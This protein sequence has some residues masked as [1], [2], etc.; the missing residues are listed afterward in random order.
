MSATRPHVIAVVVSHNGRPFL[1]DTFRALAA[2]TRPIDDIL[3]VD[4]GST[5]GSAN[6]ARSRLG[7][8]AVLAVRGK[9]GRAV[10]AA[11]RDPRTQGMDWLWLL[12]DDAAP[13]PSA[14][15]RL[16]AE[17][18]TRPKAW[19]L[20]PKLVDWSNPARLRS[21]GWSVDRTGRGV[22]RLEGEE[23][24]Q[25]QHDQ[26]T[27]VFFVS[28]AGMLVRRS[29]LVAVGGFDE[30]M[31]AWRDDLDL[32]WRM[33]L[34]GG[35]VLAVPTARVR[36]FGAAMSRAERRSILRYPRYL[37]ERHTVAS[38]IKCTSLRRLPLVL[39]LAFVGMLLRLVA[40]TLTGRPGD[41][42]QVLAAWGW[43]VKEL[44]VTLSLRRRAQ[45]RR[46]LDDAA[47]DPLRAPG[48]QRLRAVWRALLDLLDSGSGEHV[49][50]IS[51][52]E[53]DLP[54]PSGAARRFLARHPAGMM[55]AGLAVLMAVSLRSLL[56]APGIAG[57]AMALF[58][59]SARTLAAEFV[60]VFH[61]G[62]LGSTQ[63]ASPSLAVLAG[64]A[65][66]TFGKGLAA[67]KLLLWAAL[68]LAALTCT[69]ALRVLVPS[70]AVRAVAAL[71]Y[72]ASPLAVAALA[73]GRLG[74]LAF[75]VLAPPALAQVL[76][77]FRPDQP[78]ERWRPALRFGLLVGLAGA[79]YPPALVLLG[80]VAVGAAVLAVGRSDAAPRP[81]TVRQ[82]LLLLGGL[83]LALLL[84]EPWSGSLFSAASPLAALGGRQGHVPVLD[85]LQL[86]PPG[87]G[88][89][90]ALVG[91]VYPL[92]ALAAVLVT[93]PA[94]RRQAFWLVAGMLGAVAVAVWQAAGLPP[95][96]T[97][98]VGA[99]LVP[100]AV[101]WAGAA[102]LA[103]AAIGPAVRSGASSARRV[104]AVG[105]AALLALSGL[106]LAAHLARGAWAPIAAVHDAA[107]PAT[108][109]SG[110]VLWL[111][112]QPDHRVSFAVTGP[113]ARTLI[114]LGDVRPKPAADALASVV[115]D[116][117]EART[118]RGGTLLAMSGI[119]HVMVRPGPDDTR[120]IDLLARQQDLTS[121]VQ[122]GLFAGPGVP[123]AGW[124]L[125]GGPPSRVQEL[126]ASPTAAQP[127]PLPARGGSVTGPAT[128]VVPIPAG[129]AW[130]A[131]AGGTRLARTKAFG[132]AQ[133]FIVPAGV[134]GRVEQGPSGQER[135]QL[136]LVVE[137]LL[138]LAALATLARP[139]RPV[140]PAAPV[141]SE[142][143]TGELRQVQPLAAQ[144][145]VR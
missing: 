74:V 61:P 64:V 17:A 2:Q 38:A 32:C 111:Q 45:S 131:S 49:A 41:A 139:T 6:W 22:T 37:A 72:A 83:A 103:L 50:Q 91:P 53:A 88:L 132:W 55:L 13:E 100:G 109:T 39:T 60:N 104:S 77:A 31:A 21:V 51:I 78:R 129:S 8:D 108:V 12:H 145:G 65:A 4:T 116:I 27:D 128:I 42:A 75:G 114:D 66:L 89:P 25:G 16:L 92:L 107:L 30:R 36:H 82:A 48:G 119:D 136:L 62:G 47:L 35:R 110:R 137:A 120:L 97:D 63:P 33:H 68:P 105:L 3:V 76:L 96:T 143:S 118:H 5:D 20:G 126:V 93:P 52:E 71:L 70:P 34:L 102:A 95:H 43:N 28:T 106:V 94:R 24:D 125:P 90:V 123:A 112:G 124:V 87:G 98:W 86:R 130:Q 23:I 138:V 117:L 140:P 134:R 121:E 1:Q 15:E 14:L 99:A 10:M 9:F 69:R 26:I 18:G 67:Q 142:D 44:P 7:H 11:L 73:Q 115:T 80:L 54:A 144:G 79:A 127:V 58:P 56:V 46:K 101:A 19:V 122:A 81:W 57:G 113:D 40:L 133:G 85:L 135:R 29:A 84:L 59:D 141:P